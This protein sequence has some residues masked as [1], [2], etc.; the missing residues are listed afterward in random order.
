MAGK[1]INL[2]FGIGDK[3]YITHSTVG[4]N[5]LHVICPVCNGTGRFTSPVTGGTH[6]CPGVNGYVC[7]DGIIHVKWNNYYCVDEGVVRSIY[8]ASNYVHYDLDAPIFDF[9]T[10]T[11]DDMYATRHEAQLAC[12]RI[13]S[14]KGVVENG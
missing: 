9:D 6:D 10:Y 3:V 5:N 7:K 12:D 13:N 2:K 8:I 4:L 11:E 14:E 1:T